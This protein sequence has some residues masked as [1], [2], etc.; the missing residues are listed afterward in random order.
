MVRSVP[1]RGG[2]PLSPSAPTRRQLQEERAESSAFSELTQAD[3]NPL[4]ARAASL[5]RR[6]ALT[7]SGKGAVLAAPVVS[8]QAK[9]AGVQYLNNLAGFVAIKSRQGLFLQPTV[10][11]LIAGI[12]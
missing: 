9:T 6:R 3:P 8:E 12:P 10:W 7:T 2:R 5:E 4:S 11:S 1:S